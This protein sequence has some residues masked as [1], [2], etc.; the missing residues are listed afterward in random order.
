MKSQQTMVVSGPAARVKEA[1]L[2]LGFVRDHAVHH[3]T[4]RAEL[5]TAAGV[6]VFQLPFEERDGVMTLDGE[7]SFFDGLSDSEVPSIVRNAVLERWYALKSRIGGREAVPY[8]PERGDGKVSAPM[9]AKTVETA[10][11]GSM[12]QD[13]NDMLRLGKDMNRI[14]TG[15]QLKDEG[16]VSDPIQH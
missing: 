12:V 10:H 4:F 15:Q 3:S 9:P 8:S 2:H 14:K 13:F 5:D 6:C 7:A 16:L 11:N 1:L